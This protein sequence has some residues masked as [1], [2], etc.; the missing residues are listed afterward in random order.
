MFQLDRIH[1]LFKENYFDSVSNIKE[2]RTGLDFTFPSDADTWG[3]E[4]STNFH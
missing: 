2:G 4:L 3:M 1:F